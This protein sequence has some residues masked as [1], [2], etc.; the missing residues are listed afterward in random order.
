M[1]TDEMIF[2]TCILLDIDGPIRY[3]GLSVSIAGIGPLLAEAYIEGRDEQ[4]QKIG[5][6]IGSGLP[7]VWIGADNDRR[8][9]LAST[10]AKFYRIRQYIKKSDLGYGLERCLYELNPTMRCLSP[11][12][13]PDA[14]GEP[15]AL[16][17]ALDRAGPESTESTPW[18]ERHVAAFIA[19]VF[20]PQSDATL[21]STEMPDDAKS[22]QTLSG[23]VLFATAQGRSELPLLPRLSRAMGPAVL[24]LAVTYRSQTTRGRMIASLDRLLGEGDLS[25]IVKKLTDTELRARDHQ[26]YLSAVSSYNST[27]AE[28]A[29]L[30]SNVARRRLRATLIGRRIAAWVAFIGLAAITATLL[31]GLTP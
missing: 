23:L 7:L 9:S 11:L 14:C 6:M 31:T 10:T 13:E 24:E 19:A 15:V 8:K 21:A 18:T 5:A 30:E 22:A 20:H 28:I 12:I 27:K 4:A 25:A 26:A 3:K 2:R 17:S 29:V 16:L 1:S